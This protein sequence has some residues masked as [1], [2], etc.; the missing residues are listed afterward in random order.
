MLRLASDADFNGNLVRGLRRREP[1]LD[2]IRVQDIGLRTASDLDVLAWAAVNGRILL[3]HDRRT[4]VALAL[5]R[6][7]RG[8]KMP[9]LF[10]VRNRPALGPLIDQ[11][12]LIALASE[13]SEWNDQI[14]FL[15]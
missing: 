4:M 6:V 14:I 5:D 9:G 2:L 3:T 15:A 11:I 8:E 10:V 7:K 12:L 13:A 1:G